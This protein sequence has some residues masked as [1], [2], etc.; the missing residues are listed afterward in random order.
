[1]SKRLRISVIIFLIV[2]LVF[3]LYRITG[4]AILFGSQ[5]LQLDFSAYY[6]AGKSL[7]HG[8]NPY[9]NNILKGFQ[10][11]DGFAQF[12]HSRFLYPPLA[13]EVFRPLSLLNY[14]DAKTIWNILNILLYLSAFFI[15]AVRV[16]LF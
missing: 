10:Y 8:F 16:W 7:N 15:L 6:T 2:L 12:K 5:S 13:A 4:K 1:M 3:S 9:E 14:H 11:W